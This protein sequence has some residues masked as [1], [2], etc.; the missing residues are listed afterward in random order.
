MKTSS[1]VED[2]PVGAQG[3]LLHVRNELHSQ[4]LVTAFILI[5]LLFMLLPGTFLGVWNLL[6]ISEVHDADALPLG[7]LQAH[8]QAQ[9]FGWIGSFILGIGFYSLTKMQSGRKFPLVTGWWVWSLWLIGIGLRWWSGI[10]TWHWRVLFPLGAILQCIAFVLFFISVRRHRPRATSYKPEVWMQ[11][12]A[13]STV[14]F[15]IT[16]I[17]NGAFLTHQAWIGASPAVPHLLDQQFVTLAVWGVIVPTIWGFN[18]RW[19][20]IFAGLKKPDGNRLILAYVLSVAGI[21]LTFFQWWM[22]STIVLLS[23]AI[24]SIDALHIW[25]RPIQPPKLLNIHPSFPFF[26]RVAY[27]WLLISCI[28]AVLA[29][30]L[31]RSGGLWGASRHAITVGFV[32]GMV[33]AI[34][35]KI[36]PAFCGMRILWSTRWMF[37]SLCLLSVGCLLRVST[38]PLAYGGLWSPAW[39]ILPLSA[40]IEMTAITLFALN[41]GATLL[42]PPAHLRS[43]N[44]SSLSRGAA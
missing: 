39:K 30:P 15:F 11:I 8:G 24:F 43:E 22:A 35:Q 38:E 19:L 17:V 25:R 44:K 31:D 16:L 20:S 40:L 13:A 1:H 14:T 18:A 36:L 21:A 23:A 34:G 41:L 32:A 27:A 3:D 28:L 10:T 29:V 6:S 12:V 33:F 9:I 42:Q 26:L 5:G 4:Y 7:W 37:W 2:I